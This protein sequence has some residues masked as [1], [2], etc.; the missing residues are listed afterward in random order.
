M[1][2]I[3]STIASHE[4]VNLQPHK[5]FANFRR[6]GL[7]VV[8]ML[9]A[10]ATIEQTA[11]ATQTT[12]AQFQQNT[13]GNHFTFTNAAAAST[14]SA[15]N[16]PVNFQFLAAN[17][18]GAINQNIP[19]HLT[20]TSVV[21]SLAVGGFFIDQPLASVILTITAD[22]MVNGKDLLLKVNLDTG[23]FSTGHL[24]GINNGHIAL[25][26]SD[27]DPLVGNQ[28][29]F[30]S[31]FVSFVADTSRNYALS[32]SSVA[33]NLSINANGYLNGFS[34]AGTGTFAAS[35]P[36]PGSAGLALMG[37]VITFGI[38]RRFR[39]RRIVSA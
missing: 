6:A 27:T 8:L 11:V 29:E 5:F 18:Y 14:F 23:G 24:S 22:A 32:F 26:S 39:S 28:F 20:L 21:D 10:T 30:Q 7:L 9:V 35:L 19:A 25:Q 16:I 36:E 12:F 13:A 38:Q 37:T 34:G 2:T 17:A 1:K 15:V 4:R 3:D 31:D 33:P